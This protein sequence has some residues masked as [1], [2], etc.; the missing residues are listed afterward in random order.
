MKGKR[1]LVRRPAVL[2]LGGNFCYNMNT[3]KER[4]GLSPSGNY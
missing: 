2:N 4:K 3:D 1:P